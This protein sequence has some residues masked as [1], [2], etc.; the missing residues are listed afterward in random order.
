MTVFVFL[1]E[2]CLTLTVPAVIIR[3]EGLILRYPKFSYKEILQRLSNIS[4]FHFVK[5]TIISIAVGI[6]AGGIGTFFHYLYKIAENSRLAHPWLVYLLP[7]AG[8]VIALLYRYFGKDK[9]ISTNTIIHAIHTDDK[10]PKA[11]A[12]LIII[13]TLLTHLCGGSAGREG[14]ALQLGGS[15]SDT[16]LSPF[17]KKLHISSSDRHIIIMCGMAATFCALFCTP[18]T[19]VIF[20]LELATIGAMYYAALV[21]CTISSLI[22]YL[23]SNFFGFKASVYSVGFASIN[24][25]PILQTVALGAM[26]ALVSILFLLIMRIMTK[27]FKKYIKNTCL[28]AFVGGVIIIILT[29]LVGSTKYNGAGMSIVEVAMRGE[30]KFYD[31]LLKILFTAV[32][33]ASGFKGGEIVPSFFA[34]ATF[35]CSAGLLLGMDPSF[36]AALGLLGVFCG[37][38]NCPL[39]SIVLGVEL[40]GSQGILFY[41]I[42]CAV[43][44]MLSGYSG[45]YSEQSIL[46]S[47]YSATGFVKKPR[48]KRIFSLR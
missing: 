11:T 45:L 28:R 25:I 9:D 30:T 33:L 10:I 31:F 41:S 37:V 39:A 23:I 42:V 26:C 46:Y 32:T 29:L 34:G 3:K 4:I 44:Y 38:T 35:G 7:I 43:S 15:L 27:F 40:F 22:G 36:A 24:L 6:I 1:A 5:W 21:P 17:Q 18:V 13:A 47:K 14:A 16:F 2:I 8:V 19:A 12:P 20:S 48:Q